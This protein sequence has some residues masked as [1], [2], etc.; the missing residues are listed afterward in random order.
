VLSATAGS[1]INYDQ[2]DL[3]LLANAL[4]LPVEQPPPGKFDFPIAIANLG[5]A[6]SR[7]TR[8]EM[9]G[10]GQTLV[11]AA[12]PALQAGEQVTVTTTLNY[13]GQLRVARF[14]LL[15]GQPDFE[16]GNDSLELNLWAPSSAGSLGTPATT[17]RSASTAVPTAIAI[18]ANSGIRLHTASWVPRFGFGGG[19]ATI[20]AGEPPREN[21]TWNTSDSV[22]LNPGQYDVYWA[23][24]S[25]HKSKP[26]LLAAGIK[27][28]QEKFADVQASSGVRLQ[29]DPWV[30]EFGYGGRWSVVRA[31][32]AP[33]KAIDWV[34]SRDP[35]LLPPGRYDVY[36]AQDT[37]HESV[38]V[39]LA[40]GV[41][42][43]QG[44]LAGVPAAAGVRLAVAS[45]VPG[46]GYG[47]RWSVVRAGDAPGKAVNWTGDR[48]PLLLAPGRYDV[49]WT[50]DTYHEAN[51]LLLASG[52]LVDQGELVTVNANSGL[53]LNVPSWAPGFGYSGHWGVMPAGAAATGS[54][55][56]ML[57]WTA[58]PPD[59][60]LL[61][62]GRY[63]VYWVQDNY[64]E[65]IPLLLASGVEVEQSKLAVAD[66]GSGIRL[67]VASWVIP[68][69][70]AGRWGVVRAGDAP[71][72]WVHWTSSTDPLMLPP[73]R[74]D[75]YW[76]QDNYHEASPLLVATAVEVAHG[77]LVEVP[78]NSGVQL[79]LSPGSPALDA[80]S[81]WWG[82][83]PAG[84]SDP[85]KTLNRWAARSDLPLLVPPGT[86]D[87]I[88]NQGGSGKPV[89]IKQGAV[90]ERGVLVKVTVQLPR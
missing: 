52:V 44:R 58:N 27:V 50:Q 16:P 33:G 29:V 42:V 18:T 3:A 73:G 15:Q 25:D 35:L 12:V 5:E 53:R 57:H 22:R 66:A 86:Y 23:Q 20:R 80:F 40:S 13:D 84:S 4:N 28:E 2:P 59:A 71:G 39:L 74:Y 56:K 30:P 19:W 48:V 79:Q 68:F 49:Y 88:W 45:W 72:K 9:S 70:Y 85:E 78:V 14:R 8:L 61:P 1:P 64:H 41:L 75:V 83:V 76:V 67:Q 32:D 55:G 51:L 65:A 62:P 46:F 47:G 31:G 34:A 63:D 26:V 21:T 69:G 82:V 36:W 54:A 38:P 6:P 17:P 77:K 87:V 37:Y 11:D 60:L 81:G 89:R 7:P 24:D 10:G 43:E 90:V